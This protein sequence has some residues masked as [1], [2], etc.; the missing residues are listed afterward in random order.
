MKVVFLTDAASK[1]ASIGHQTLELRKASPKRIQLA[2][3]LSG[4]VFEALRAIG[5]EHIT[6]RIIEQLKDSL[7]RE[8]RG[9]VLKDLPHAPAWMH[10]IIIE[11]T[12]ESAQW[13]SS[14]PIL[15]SNEN[16]P[17]AKLPPIQHSSKPF[18]CVRCSGVTLNQVFS[19]AHQAFRLIESF[20]SCPS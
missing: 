15:P 19:A 6:E 12:K 18:M 8:D 17:S 1:K 16:E 11:V 3:R 9:K 13:I 2:G 4:L 7:Q 5:K 20:Q 10:S 14:S